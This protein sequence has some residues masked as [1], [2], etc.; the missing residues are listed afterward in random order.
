MDCKVI[1]VCTRTYCLKPVNKST[2]HTIA[3]AID[4]MKLLRG[5]GVTHSVPGKTKLFK[6]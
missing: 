4:N 5:G 6:E 3:K 1:S 2:I